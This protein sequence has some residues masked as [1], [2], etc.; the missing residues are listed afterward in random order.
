[1]SSFCYALPHGHGPHSGYQFSN[2]LRSGMLPARQLLRA[3]KVTNHLVPSSSIHQLQGCA[4]WL[5][6][7]SQ[8]KLLLFS[9]SCIYPTVLAPQR[10][11][12]LEDRIREQLTDAEPPPSSYDTAWVAMVP[13]PGRPYA[14]RFP[15]CL[16]WIMQNQHD[17]GSWGLGPSLGLGVKNALLSTL[18]CVLALMKWGVGDEHIRKG[19]CFIQ[20]NSSPITDDNCDVPVGFNIIFPGMLE[21]GVDMGL[22]LPLSHADVD[23]MCRLRDTELKRLARP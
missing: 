12:L 4:L 7:S 23:A 10:P 11:S 22:E 6:T 15:Q 14:P 9:C 13:A 21:L 18:A 3:T 19:L 5:S 16:E 2:K 20:R 8:K 1:M 17:D